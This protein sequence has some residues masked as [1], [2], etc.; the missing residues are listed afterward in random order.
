[1]KLTSNGKLLTATLLFRL[2]FG[3]YI[4]GMDQYLFKDFESAVTVVIIYLFLAIF[5]SFFIYGKRIGLVGIISL[6]TIFIILNSVFLIVT[7]GQITDAGMHDPLNNW[8][9]TIF[10]FA[11]SLLTLILSIRIYR[12]TKKGS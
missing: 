8:W 6:E 9:T 12:E 11:F 5:S 1:M 3:G 2:L 10:R 4:I 7:L